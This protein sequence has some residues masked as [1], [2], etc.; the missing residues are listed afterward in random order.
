MSSKIYTKTGDKGDTS[1]FN[2]ERVS[3]AEASIRTLGAIDECNSTLGV[4]VAFLPTDVAYA[5]LRRE[6]SIIQHALFDVGAAVATPRTRASQNK[7]AKTRFDGEAIAFLEQWID[8][9]QTELSPL[10]V[11]ILPG[12][13]PAG[14]NLHLA[15]TICRR[16]ECHAVPLY[17]SGD[18]DEELLIYLNR[19]SD[20]LF[21]AARRVNTLS[22][23]PEQAWQHH[24]TSGANY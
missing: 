10:K 24:L 9:H 16:A 22:G 1:L 6:L 11:F 23:S 20:Y 12:G 14:A 2:G 4:A 3:K 5:G 21:V 18:I 15:R 7:L 8:A 13:H 19:L 17:H